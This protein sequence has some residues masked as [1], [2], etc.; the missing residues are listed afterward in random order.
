MAHLSCLADQ[1]SALRAYQGG[2][3]CATIDGHSLDV[4]AV[5]AVSRNG[6]TPGIDSSDDTKARIAAAVAVV[7]KLAHGTHSQYGV[8]TGYG[9]CATTRTRQTALLQKALLACCNCGIVP[10]FDT[11]ELTPDDYALMIPQDWIRATM[12][13]RLNSIIRAQ[14]GT[15][16]IVIEGLHKL[17]TEGV[18]PCAPLRQSISASGDLG[19]LSYISSVLTGNPNIRAFYGKG[20]VLTCRLHGDTQWVTLSF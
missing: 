18:A 5:I 1:L 8:T 15:R 10:A 16:W 9:A 19:P 3:R 17:L 2:S 13:V 4:P 20:L 11:E 12:F 14:S 7:Q 6:H